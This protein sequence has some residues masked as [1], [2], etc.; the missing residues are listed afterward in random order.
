[1]KVKLIVWAISLL[2]VL[3]FILSNAAAIELKFLFKT[4]KVSAIVVILVSLI[5]GFISGLL[6]EGKKKKPEKKVTKSEEE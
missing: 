5:I 4:F 2:I 6:V 3:I 1:V